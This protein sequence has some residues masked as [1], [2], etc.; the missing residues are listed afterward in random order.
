[1]RTIK[2]LVYGY[3]LTIG[4][5]ICHSV[6]AGPCQEHLEML[7]RIA[8]KADAIW[9][10]AKEK[11]A[12]LEKEAKQTD[13]IHTGAV[14]EIGKETATTLE[15][16]RKELSETQ[17]AIQELIA[18]KASAA[19]QVK[20]WERKKA[21][22]ESR[23][24]ELGA[25]LHWFARN[26][27]WAAT[28][29]GRLKV[30]RYQYRELKL[31]K[32]Q[33]ELAN[34]QKQAEKL[35]HSEDKLTN[36]QAEITKKLQDLTTE[37]EDSKQQRILEETISKQKELLATALKEKETAKKEIRDL[38][39]DWLAA[40]HALYQSAEKL[41][42]AS[43]ELEEPANS[44]LSAS[45]TAKKAIAMAQEEVERAQVS[46]AVNGVDQFFSDRSTTVGAIT[47]ALN[48]FDAQVGLTRAQEAVSR[49]SQ[50]LDDVQQ[51]ARR[52]ESMLSQ[53]QKEQK[54][55]KQQLEP[56][57]STLSRPDSVIPLL[58][59]VFDITGRQNNWTGALFGASRVI[60]LGAT[61]SD[62]SQAATEMTKL[63]SGV[64]KLK[65]TLGGLM[66]ATDKET[67]RMIDEA[68]DA[69]FEK[70]TTQNLQKN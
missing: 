44:T 13:S 67:T 16:L 38:V 36:N 29:A 70:I 19:E 6:L 63:S 60:D 14:L 28:H 21:R 12:R 18:T 1:M 62:L 34:S 20:L 9:R 3:I 37:S 40:N 55:L 10:S 8:P 15:N 47:Q 27:G 57:T 31:E 5:T 2:L 11:A 33:T 32:L 56:V 45:E 59:T 69:V 23:M 58:D 17:G 4:I 61:H 64:Q 25:E 7:A 24:E 22:V 46:A 43:E 30:A 39:I 53:F 66:G 50:S 26:L 49:A 65:Q 42:R 35:K 51:A 48:S 68:F 41:K 52:L 54:S